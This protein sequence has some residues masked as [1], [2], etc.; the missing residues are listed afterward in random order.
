MNKENLFIK[1]P[2]GVVYQNAKGEITDAN[3]SAQEILGLSIEQMQG[4]KSIDPRWKS[5]KEDGSDFPGNEHP[6]I[7][8]L[9]T[10]RVIQDVIMGVFHPKKNDIV[11]INI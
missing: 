1:F 9:N 6:A 11:W 4:R 3:K 5:I 2:I 10:G 8:A 7:I